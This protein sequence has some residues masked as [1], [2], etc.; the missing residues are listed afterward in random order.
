M[1]NY[2]KSAKSEGQGELFRRKRSEIPDEERVLT[3]QRK[4]Y[5]KAKT[6]KA[7]KFYV[8]YDKLFIP[9]MLREAW[10][11]VKDN[12]GSAG[13]DKVRIEDVERYGAGQYL[14]ELG[15][16][17]RTK[18]YR[19]SPVRRVMIEKENGG[20]RPLG[21]PTVRD[22]IV[23]TACKMILEPIFEADFNEDSYGYRPHRSTKDAM[24]AIREQLGKGKVQVYDADLS[25]YFDS[26]PHDKLMIALQT[27][28]SDP[29]I[30]KLIMKW[31]KVPVEEDGQLRS[32]KGRKNGTPQGGVMSPLLANIYMHLLDRI[33][34]NANN[35]FGKAGIRMIR[36]ADDFILMG[37][38]IPK[39]VEDRLRKLLKRMGLTLNELKTRKVDAREES[40]N[41]LGYTVRYDKDRY[42]RPIKYWNVIPSKKADAKI[43]EKVRIFFRTHGHS[44]PVELAKGLNAILRGWM[45]YQDI[46][47]ISYPKDS[48][49]RLRYYLLTKTNRYYRRKSQRKC[50][51]L[52]GQAAFSV[53]VK[54]YGLIDPAAWRRY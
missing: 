21:I 34:N 26:I 7:Y 42:G 41:F 30:L 36:Y 47:G 20:Q 49:R 43:R 29:R 14:K 6:D 9:Y 32:G 51:R 23:Q 25:N 53:L 10:E 18:R 45:N 15:E 12:G 1:K 46:A 4:L 11:Q 38:S 48:F 19:P 50:K 8:L 2:H 39:E 54:Q 17:I 35:M 28:V 52:Y 3:L 40:F 5:Q 37:E 22:R 44:N 33:V 31:L 13:I 27:R 24:R 16:E